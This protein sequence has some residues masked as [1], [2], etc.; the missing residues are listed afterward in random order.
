MTTNMESNYDRAKEVKEFDETKAGVK[1]L[2]DA[3]AVKIPRIFIHVMEKLENRLSENYETSLQVPVIDLG[4]FK[5]RPREEIVN[6]ISKASETWGFFQMV[7]H[8]IPV[9]VMEEMIGGIKRFHE[10]PREVKTEWYSRD[11]KQRVRFYCNGD[12]LVAKSANWR[13]SIACQYDDGVLDSDALPLVCRKEISNYMD[14]LIRLKEELSKLLSEA[15]GL[16]SDFLSNIDCMKTASL[17]CHYYPWC[18]E[19][20][21]TLGAS[22]HSDPSFLTILLQDNIGGLQVLHQ[23]NWVD[24]EP[25]KGALIANIGD[26]MQLITNDK[27]KSVEHR[28]LASRVGPRISAACFFYPSLA[29]KCKP[30]GPIKEILSNNNPPIYR[31]TP[32]KEYQAYYR[33]KGL[34][35]TSALLH[36]KL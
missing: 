28:V 23:N 31:E 21:L 11:V 12:L 2:L 24:V 10:Q 29:S 5:N 34:D 19:P 26:L 4:D 15:L 3:G 20:D 36:F 33:S 32:H 13:D 25:V 14:G 35:G 18:P 9:G 7:N 30:Y 16:S 17:V 6:E 1:G 8:G 27:F 22:K